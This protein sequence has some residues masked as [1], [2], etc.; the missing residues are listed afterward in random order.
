MENRY[1]IKRESTPNWNE[2]KSSS[3]VNQKN[4]YNHPV[5]TKG[6][7]KGKHFQPDIWPI[8]QRERISISK[9]KTV[10]IKNQQSN[11][12]YEIPDS[13]LCISICLPGF[14]VWFK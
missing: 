5:M 12:D 10:S 11:E 1:L 9:E 3:L 4:T 7:L 14:F 13:L 2:N 8:Y 6:L